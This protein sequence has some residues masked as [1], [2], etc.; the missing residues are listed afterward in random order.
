MAY[1]QQRI[2]SSGTSRW[3]AMYFTA[4]GRQRSGGGFS[5][6]R[7]AERAAIKL[8]QHAAA[9]TLAGAARGKLTFDAYVEKYYWPAAQHLEPTTLAAY[10]SN[11]DRHF[12]PHFG[13]MRMSRIV[14]STVQAWVNEVSV[15]VHDDEGSASRG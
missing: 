9:G 3:Y 6:K 5:A 13:R 7:D 12:L 8:E 14:A 2:T 11:L 1:A 15:E 10:R 4:D